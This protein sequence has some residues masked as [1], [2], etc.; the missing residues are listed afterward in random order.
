M[1][2]C[3]VILSLLLAAC[4][5]PAAPPPEDQQPGG[6]ALSPGQE[7]ASIRQDLG[8]TNNN[9]PILQET[10]TVDYAPSATAL[11]VWHGPWGAEF[12]PFYG[13]AGLGSRW[14][15]YQGNSWVNLNTPFDPGVQFGGSTTYVAPFCDGFNCPVQPMV[16][17]G[18]WR[19]TERVSRTY[20]WV[21]RVYY[22]YCQ[23]G[24]YTNNIW[25]GAAVNTAT[26]GTTYLSGITVPGI[27]KDPYMWGNI[28]QVCGV[29]NDGFSTHQ[30]DV[31]FHDPSKRFCFNWPNATVCNSPNC[32]P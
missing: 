4:Q 31:C 29:A 3:I 10:V 30:Y 5:E 15:Q 16:A 21:R 26:A 23:T 9:D 13:I 7:F 11:F 27:W 12:S 20:G 6:H 24:H 18:S 17:S 22:V 14:Q 19:M 8:T 1:T 25:A 28:A 2:K 32:G